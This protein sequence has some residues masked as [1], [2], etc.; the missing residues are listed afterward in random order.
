MV[1]GGRRWQTSPPLRPQ[2]VNN[3]AALGKC[4]VDNL[5]WLLNLSLH[6]NKTRTGPLRICIADCF[7]DFNHSFE[8]DPGV[9]LF[10][11]NPQMPSNPFD[12]SN[13][14]AFAG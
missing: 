9:L 11:T 1:C 13:N 4:A 14:N 2:S 8:R 3:S 12:A 6:K 7:D 10:V 5:L